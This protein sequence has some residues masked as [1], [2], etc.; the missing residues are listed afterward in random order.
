MIALSSIMFYSL[1]SKM[2]KTIPIKPRVSG[3]DAGHETK[4]NERLHRFLNYSYLSGVMIAIS[5][6]MI[7]SFNEHKEYQGPVIP[8]STWSNLICINSI[9]CIV[10]TFRQRS[11]AVAF[12]DQPTNT[13]ATVIDRR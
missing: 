11:L 4:K 12:V 2:L 7:Y 13:F 6:I 9:L 10:S 1:I 8:I 3:I 5:S